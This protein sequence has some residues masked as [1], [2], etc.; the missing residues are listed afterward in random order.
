MNRLTAIPPTPLEATPIAYVDF[1]KLHPSITK[2]GLLVR[3]RQSAK[4]A[5]QKAP[6]WVLDLQDK[7]R[8]LI[9]CKHQDG[10]GRCSL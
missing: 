6:L 10:L 4:Q 5:S 9:Y 3:H 7:A 1:V 2:G 8:N